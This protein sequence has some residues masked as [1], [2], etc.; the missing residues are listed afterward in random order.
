MPELE[1]IVTLLLWAFVTVTGSAA[2]VLCLKAARAIFRAFQNNPENSSLVK[3]VNT[4]D[5]SID[6]L[7]MTVSI[8]VSS[9]GESVK[10]AF[11][12]EFPK[13]LTMI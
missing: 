6:Y 2:I 4:R 12:P 8:A 13:C 10:F 5:H 1:E 7:A 9:G 3:A 11:E